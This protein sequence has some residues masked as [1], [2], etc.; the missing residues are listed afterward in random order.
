MEEI[1]AR[2]SRI[3]AEAVD[4]PPDASGWAG[5][6]LAGA[7]VGGML[8][9]PLGMLLGASAGGNLATSGPSVVTRDKKLE[10][11]GVDA[12]VRKSVEQSQ[13]DCEE[14]QSAVQS[15]TRARDSARSFA[16]TL[17]R[18][19]DAAQ[20]A[21][22]EAVETGDDDAA[23]TYLAS[24]LSLDDRVARAED[25]LTEAQ[26]RLALAAQ[27]LEFFNER[28]RDLEDLVA[29]TICA[30]DDRKRGIDLDD[31]LDDGASSFAPRDPLLDR[32]KALED[33]EQSSKSS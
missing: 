25:Q 14:G 4:L 1:R 3:L 13:R 2:A 32:F 7:V 21:A 33:Q 30:T 11:L 29:R 10:A 20:L 24:R 8:L 6:T 23:R 16:A 27:N 28:A 26:K 31:D 17:A 12:D 5:G 18:D 15:A 19:R 22:R 9:G